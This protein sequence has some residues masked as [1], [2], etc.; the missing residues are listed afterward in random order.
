MD[1]GAEVGNVSSVTPDTPPLPL[2]RVLMTQGLEFSFN[3]AM[4]VHI[5]ADL[6]VL[7][8]SFPLGPR[9]AVLPANSSPRMRLR[10]LAR[11]GSLV[12]CWGLAMG[13]GACCGWLLVLKMQRVVDD[14]VLGVKVLVGPPVA[15]W[16]SVLG[17]RAGASPE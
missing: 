5:L 16:G 12:A 3:L 14:E 7:G 10:M 15:H 9:V 6:H 17:A 11:L 2:P 1:V 4:M 8:G 13:L